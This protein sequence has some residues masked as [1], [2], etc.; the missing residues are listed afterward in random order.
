MVLRFAKVI[1]L[2]LVGPIF[3]SC[4]TTCVGL[5]IC[6]VSKRYLEKMSFR[7]EDKLSS[8]EKSEKND[9]MSVQLDHK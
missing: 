4:Y 7:Q 6:F 1:P 5:L 8:N 9:G 2:R 3:S